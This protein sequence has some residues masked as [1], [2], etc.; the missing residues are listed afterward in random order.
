MEEERDN[1]ELIHMHQ[2]GYIYLLSNR[3]PTKN[4]LNNEEHLLLT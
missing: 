4:G 2:S 1:R 3:K